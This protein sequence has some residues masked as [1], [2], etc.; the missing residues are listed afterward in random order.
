VR[1]FAL[2]LIE[3]ESAMLEKIT[4]S[5]ITRL[6][7]AIGINIS[8]ISITYGE[9]SV[10]KNK[11]TEVKV[12][13]GYISSDS[14]RPA[15]STQKENLPVLLNDAGKI[16]AIVKTSKPSGETTLKHL[17]FLRDQ[18]ILD[19]KVPLKDDQIKSVS[20]L[21]LKPNWTGKWRVDITA[22]DGTLLYSIPFLIQKRPETQQTS[23]E[24]P[25][26]ASNNPTELSHI[27]M[28]NPPP[29]RP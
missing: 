17:W 1:K 24:A 15:V 7:L 8:M 21:I 3:K 12:L 9:V 10:D 20:G 18:I 25:F 19:A 4:K 2:P 26:S 28:T 14:Y 23:N 27:S 16:Y 11:A 6:I 13:E 5:S 29:A 22:Q